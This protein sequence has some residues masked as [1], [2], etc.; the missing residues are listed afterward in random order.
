[1]LQFILSAAKRDK[2]RALNLS[3]ELQ[4]KTSLNPRIEIILISIW[5][6]NLS[7]SKKENISQFL[8]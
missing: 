6:L 5:R 8:D 1:M 2:K 7:H 3:I 4:N